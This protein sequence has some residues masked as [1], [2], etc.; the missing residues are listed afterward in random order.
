MLT[1]I[2]VRGVGGI[3]GCGRELCW[4]LPIGIAPETVASDLAG[5]WFLIVT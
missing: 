3:W 5:Q 2:G 1:V 4:A